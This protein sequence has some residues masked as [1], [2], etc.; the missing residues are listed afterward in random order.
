[1]YQ[2]YDLLLLVVADV[3][4]SVTVRLCQCDEIDLA[5]V[6]VLYSSTAANMYS[7]GVLLGVEW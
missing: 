4:T 5:A 3:L 1:M 6:N 7:I 2:C